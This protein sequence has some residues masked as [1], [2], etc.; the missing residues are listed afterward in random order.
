MRPIPRT[1]H[2]EPVPVVFALHGSLPTR[3]EKALADGLVGQNA[4]I[5]SP[6]YAIP[7]ARDQPIHRVANNSRDKR[8]YP[9]DTPRP[10]NRCHR[11]D[12]GTQIA[13]YAAIDDDDVRFELSRIEAERPIDRCPQL[14][15]REGKGKPLTPVQ[16]HH[17]PEKSGAKNTFAVEDD[18][19]RSANDLLH[20]GWQARDA[21]N[22]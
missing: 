19:I 6:E 11:S 12:K 9:E 1:A 2:P 22:H 17:R 13:V 3:I 15:L 20:F 4:G 14:R 21:P 5:V 7:V 10:S 18:Q 8:E 16:F